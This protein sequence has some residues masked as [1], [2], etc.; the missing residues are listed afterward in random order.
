MSNIALN[1]MNW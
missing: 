1:Q